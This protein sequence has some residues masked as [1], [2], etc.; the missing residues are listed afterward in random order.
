M[1]AVDYKP[2]IDLPQRRALGGRGAR[3]RQPENDKDFS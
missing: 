3:N 2:L 1:K